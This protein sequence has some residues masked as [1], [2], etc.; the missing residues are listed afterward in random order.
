MDEVTKRHRRKNTDKEHTEGKK[1]KKHRRR[2]TK[3]THQNTGIILIGTTTRRRNITILIST[4]H[5]QLNKITR[6]GDARY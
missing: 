4:F 3:K 5:R 6:G 2:S 1:E